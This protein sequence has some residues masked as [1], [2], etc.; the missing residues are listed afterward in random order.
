MQ[1]LTA[2]ANIALKERHTSIQL[3]YSSGTADVTA[4]C[5]YD[6]GKVRGDA[7]MIFYGQPQSQGISL[8]H[9]TLTMDCAALPADIVKIA[10]CMT[11]DSNNLAPLGQLKLQL[12]DGNHVIATAEET[13][14]GRSEA[15]L[16]VGEWY[17]RAAAWKFRLVMQ[18]FNGG[19]RPLAEHFGVEIS[20][21]AEPSEPAPTPEPP[22]TPL[23]LRKHKVGVELRKLGIEQEKMRVILVMDASGSMSSTYRSGKVQ[24]TLERLVPVASKLDDDGQLEFYYYASRFAYLGTIN[25]HHMTDFIGNE[26]PQ[27]RQAKDPEFK[28]R[29]QKIAADIKQNIDLTSIGGSNNEPPVMEDILQRCHKNTGEP[30]LVLFITDGG[31]SHNAAIKHILREASQRALF[32]QFIGLGNANYGILRKLDTLDGRIVD[33]AGFFAVDDISTISD[34]ELYHR[35]LSELPQW[36]NE[37][38]RLNIVNAKTK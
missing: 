13:L 28:I 31:V 29:L 23:D 27:K 11:N 26:M 16:I 36:L 19:L 35:L 21:D 2:G 6:N 24:E 32:W 12:Q 10:I 38:R 30:T 25:E 18:G 17:R 33:N 15:A 8:N 4:Y 22:R 9:H 34:D 7:D 37:A 3:H 14:Q 5:L 20:D 1:N